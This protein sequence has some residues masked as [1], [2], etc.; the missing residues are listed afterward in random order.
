MTRQSYHHGDLRA[1]VVDEA[2]ALLEKGSPEDLSLREVARNVG[3]SA[4]AVYRHFPSKE[5]L[6]KALAH[7]GLALL[8]EQQRKS[9]ARSGGTEGFAQTGRAY[10]RFALNHPNLFR[11]IFIHS[12][13]HM[14]PETSS[15]EGS[16]AWLLRHYIGQALGPRAT[17][18]QVFASVLRAWALVHGLSMLILDG[19]V[20]RKAAEAMI[21]QVIA[22]D[23]RAGK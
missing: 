22:P 13:G 11:L 20:E 3:V 10:V 15:P 7:H 6:L 17:P 19:Q 18:E 5:D 2:L 16:P 12:P 14:R 21:D 9:A 1:A 4:T 23:R 8:G